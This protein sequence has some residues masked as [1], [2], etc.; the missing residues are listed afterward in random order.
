[1]RDIFAQCL[2]VRQYDYDRDAVLAKYRDAGYDIDEVL[3]EFVD[4]YIEMR[5]IWLSG[6]RTEIELT[7]DSRSY[8]HTHRVNMIRSAKIVSADLWPVGELFDAA[9][10]LVLGSDRT[11][12]VYGDG[13]IQRIDVGFAET[14]QALVSD[15]WDKTF[16]S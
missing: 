7:T 14:L 16:L 6:E 5:F 3:M 15:R 9:T 2:W 8:M 4:N 11:F 1:M 10:T 13:G 12:Y